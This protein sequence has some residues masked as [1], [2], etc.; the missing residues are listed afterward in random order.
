M[1]FELLSEK[2]KELKSPEEITTGI[3][4]KNTEE[5]SFLNTLRIEEAET[6]RKYFRRYI[7]YAVGAVAYF[8]IFIL[9]ADPDLTLR[10]RIA[11]T[12]FVVAFAILAVLSRK[13]F[14]EIKRSSFLDSQKQFLKNA[15]KSYLFWNKQ[16][17]WLIPVLLFINAG[18]TFSVSNHFGD[19]NITTGVLLFQLA[20]WCLLGFGFYMGKKAWTNKKKPV[21]NKI[22]AI[23]LEFEQ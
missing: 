1:N 19:L 7:L 22:E 14:S 9:N 11:G 2:Y 4:G 16:Q 12:C 21:L 20:F 3:L 17:L 13:R 8:S 15:R 10:N 18:A 5:S 23:L 6:R